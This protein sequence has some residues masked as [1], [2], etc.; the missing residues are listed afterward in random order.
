[1][2]FAI[3]KISIFF[4]RNDFLDNIFEFFKKIQYLPQFIYTKCLL[5]CYIEVTIR[6][7][8]SEYL[9]P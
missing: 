7:N 9:L 1:M 4:K 6:H 5:N 8:L 3:A 2:G